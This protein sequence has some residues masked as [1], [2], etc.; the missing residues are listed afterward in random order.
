MALKILAIFFCSLPIVVPV[1]LLLKTIDKSSKKYRFCWWGL[2]SV[3]AMIC[4]GTGFLF[5][6]L[7]YYFPGENPL[8]PG[9]DVFLRV[10][11][12]FLVVSTIAPSYPALFIL[13]LYPPKSYSPKKQQMIRILVRTSAT[14]LIAIVLILIKY[15]SFIQELKQ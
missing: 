12:S 2:V 1:T 3:T 15:R 8:G 7:S 13:G 6:G 14:V 5:V 9:G 10:L 11:F 4:L